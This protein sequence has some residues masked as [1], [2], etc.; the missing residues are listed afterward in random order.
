MK[1]SMRTMFVLLAI[2]MSLVAVQAAW[3]K[4]CNLEVEGTVTA[5][6]YD[7]NSITIDYNTIIYGVRLEYLANKLNIV[8]QVG[9]N[10]V[11]TALQCPSTGKLSACTVSVVAP[12]TTTA[13]E[14]ICDKCYCNCP[15]DC[16]DCPCDCS[17]VCTCDGTGPKGPK[18]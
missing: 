15:E 18:K 14:C 13:S 4:T 16:P 5:I 2:V 10:V 3:A 12:L 17:C 9:D 11:I 7:N 1:R 8:L 6:D